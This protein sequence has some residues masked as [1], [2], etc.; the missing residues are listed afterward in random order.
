[1]KI[2]IIIGQMCGWVRR[3]LHAARVGVVAR[4]GRRPHTGR[5]DERARRQGAPIARRVHVLP[6]GQRAQSLRGERSPA[7]SI[8]I[9]STSLDSKPTAYSILRL[10][11]PI[12][13]SCVRLTSKFSRTHL[14]AVL[15]SYCT[16]HVPVCILR[17]PSSAFLFLSTLPLL[18]SVYF[19]TLYC[20]STYIAGTIFLS[21]SL[22]QI[23]IHQS[24]TSA[25]ISF[26]FL[27]LSFKCS[28]LSSAFHQ[29]ASL[30]VQYLTRVH[31]TL[32][33]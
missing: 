14:C 12:R 13:V 27:S 32:A 6:A 31:E 11:E 2:W 23:T 1:M 33:K 16:L 22:N 8:L 15:Y 10:H 5:D 9:R 25:F 19:C 4:V 7:R 28:M 30:Q 18:C 3:P 24:V 26:L 29:L 20:T 17:T 21:Q